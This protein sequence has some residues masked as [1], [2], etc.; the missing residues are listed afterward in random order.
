MITA[1]T[2]GAFA[3]LPV[4]FRPSRERRRPD[5]PSEDKNSWFQA[6]P[7]RLASGG[8]LAGVVENAVDA[9]LL[10]RTSSA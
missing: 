8:R 4:R 5:H 3:A 1:D 7:D 9:A 2:T 10:D 6:L